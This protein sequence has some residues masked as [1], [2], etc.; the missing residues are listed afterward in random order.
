M[1]QC[2]FEMEEPQKSKE[3]YYKLLDEYPY[4]VY[5]EEALEQLADAIKIYYFRNK[6]L[7]IEQLKELN[8]YTSNR[9]SKALFLVRIADIYF[10][11][12]QYQKALT[13]YKNILEKHPDTLHIE[14]IKYK[15]EKC[16]E[17]L[18]K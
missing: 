12:Q 2:Y 11:D 1:A 6:Q 15:I 14:W 16:K 7:A 4:S 8:K 3:I 10:L 5:K 9:E 18:K 13:T 17:R